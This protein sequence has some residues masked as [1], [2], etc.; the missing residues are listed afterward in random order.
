[1]KLDFVIQSLSIIVV[2]DV[3]YEQQYRAFNNFEQ[4]FVN[5]LNVFK[6]IYN[7]LYGTE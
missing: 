2:V 5:F 6:C 4:N 3:H 1:M 7:G